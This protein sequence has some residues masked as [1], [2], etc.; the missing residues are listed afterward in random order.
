MM[1]MLHTVAKRKPIFPNDFQASSKLE[2]S[3]TVSSAVKSI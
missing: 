1:V 2:S 3:S